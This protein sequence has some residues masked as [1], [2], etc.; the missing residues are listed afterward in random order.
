MNTS[1]TTPSLFHRL[2]M[3]AEQAIRGLNALQP[4]AQ[5]WARWYVAGVFFRSGL[6]KIHDWDTTLA[7][8]SDEYHVPLL[9]PHVAAVMG[10]S[11][12]LALPALILLGLSTRFAAAGLSILNVVAVL[13]VEDMPV[14]AF[15]LHVFWGSLLMGL[16]LW[17]AGRWSVD[18]FL[19]P[20]LKQRFCS[21]TAMGD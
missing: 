7:L 16:L 15:Q 10:T 20:R 13:S 2:W 6:T 1:P 9:S 12:E 19:W 5:L 3:W 21:R 18:Q 11:A 17:G 4:A 8:F 14:A